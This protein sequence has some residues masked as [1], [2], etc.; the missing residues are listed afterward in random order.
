[1]IKANLRKYLNK[2]QRLRNDSWGNN[3]FKEILFDKWQHNTKLCMSYS[4]CS[5]I[6]MVLGFASQYPGYPGYQLLEAL[7][8]LHH[9]VHHFQERTLHRRQ[10]NP[11]SMSKGCCMWARFKSSNFEILIFKHWNFKISKF[12]LWIFKISK[13]NLWIFKIGKFKF[14]NFEICHFE[15]SQQWT[16]G[17]YK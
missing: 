5:S 9:D 17:N 16:G 6:L 2:L 1:M 8:I 10:M 4:K 11:S 12:N 14:W 13:F 7:W 15:L 3:D